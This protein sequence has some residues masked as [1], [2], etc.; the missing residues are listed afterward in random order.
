MPFFLFASM[1]SGFGTM[2]FKLPCSKK[3]ND[4]KIERMTRLD[5]QLRDDTIKCRNNF[6]IPIGCA[7]ELILECQWPLYCDRMPLV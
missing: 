7:N 4:L 3:V 2:T 6:Q 5:E 1:A